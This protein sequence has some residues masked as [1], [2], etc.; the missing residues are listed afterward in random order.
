MMGSLWKWK[1]FKGLWWLQTELGV[2]LIRLPVVHNGPAQPNVDR[3]LYFVSISQES[4]IRKVELCS[5][6]LPKQS[7]ENK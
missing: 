2:H 6:R 3:S 7:T 1:M 4:V 5:I